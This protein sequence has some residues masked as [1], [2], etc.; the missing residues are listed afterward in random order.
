MKA[1]F[2]GFCGRRQ[3]TSGWPEM[4]FFDHDPMD[5]YL[6]MDKAFDA[7]RSGEL[8]SGDIV[9]VWDPDARNVGGFGLKGRLRTFVVGTLGGQPSLTTVRRR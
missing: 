5:S 9:K 7:I 6:P 1:V 8:K 3:Q 2:S 4:R